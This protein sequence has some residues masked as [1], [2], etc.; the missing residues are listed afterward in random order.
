MSLALE[1]ER[2]FIWKHRKMAGADIIDL[3]SEE[4]HKEVFLVL[5][6]LTSLWFV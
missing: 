2:I 1:A 5:H 6:F 4:L 3:L